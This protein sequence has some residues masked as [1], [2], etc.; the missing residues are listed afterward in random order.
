MRDYSGTGEQIMK[1]L[2]AKRVADELS[3]NEEAFTA[4]HKAMQEGFL[5]MFIK[6]FFLYDRFASP[7][8]VSN[9]ENPLLE[10]SATKMAGV[11]ALR[12][13]GDGMS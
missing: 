5:G 4:V 8:L 12:M 3:A 1:S 11:L 6:S 10:K 2:L 13:E 7:L 9:P